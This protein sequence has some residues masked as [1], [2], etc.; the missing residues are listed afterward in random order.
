[1]A[2]RNRFGPFS[3]RRAV[4]GREPRGSDLVCNRT[5]LA[6]RERPPFGA[7]SP[8][9][10]AVEDFGS[11]AFLFCLVESLEKGGLVIGHG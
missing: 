4:I 3:E 11:G 7:E 8:L 5:D 6:W 10:L 2:E 9:H 1:L